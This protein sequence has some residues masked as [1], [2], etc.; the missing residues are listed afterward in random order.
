[1]RFRAGLE[2]PFLHLGL[3][4]LSWIARLRIVRDWSRYAD[5]MLR[6]SRWFERLGSDIGGMHVALCGVDADGRPLARRWEIIATSGHGP[7]IPATAAVVIARK[8][9]SGALPQ[10]GARACLD[11]FTLDEFLAELSDFD[12]VTRVRAAPA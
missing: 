1:V 5:P 10:R 8:L 4:A 9:A 6:A 12:I 11:L 2:L 7:E 3:W